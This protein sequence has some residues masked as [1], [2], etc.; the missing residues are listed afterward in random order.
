[1]IETTFKEKPIDGIDLNKGVHTYNIYT[2][3]NKE[4]IHILSDLNNKINE[5]ILPNQKQ[6]NKEYFSYKNYWR[7]HYKQKM[8]N[9]NSNKT[10]SKKGKL[11]KQEFVSLVMTNKYRRDGE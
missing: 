9:Y 5:R 10:R 7:K 11:T 3:L 6:L 1:M 2:N 4:N 8:T